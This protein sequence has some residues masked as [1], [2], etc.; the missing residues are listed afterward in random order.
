MKIE[1]DLSMNEAILVFKFLKRL[2]LARV[3]EY[4]KRKDDDFEFA[5]FKTVIREAKKIAP[6]SSF[7]SSCEKFLAQRRFLSKKQVHALENIVDLSSI[8]DDFDD[9]D[10]HDRNDMSRDEFDWF[11]KF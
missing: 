6:N 3:T 5:Y 2:K 7:V 10:E 8:E 9:I 1:L 4:V 11:W